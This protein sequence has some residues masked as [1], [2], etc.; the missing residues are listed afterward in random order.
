MARNNAPRLHTKELQE[1]RRRFDLI[2]SG[3]SDP[4]R[5]VHSIYRLLGS[6]QDRVDTL[7]LTLQERNS[8]LRFTRGKLERATAKVVPSVK[9]KV[10]AKKEKSDGKS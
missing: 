9:V 3:Q 2:I 1:L 7:E 5:A 10:T 4:K 6:C 8:E